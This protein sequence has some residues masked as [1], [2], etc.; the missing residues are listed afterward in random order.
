MPMSENIKLIKQCQKG[1]HKAFDKVINQYSGLIYGI[2]L[3]YCKN[4][5]EAEDLLQ[6]C[7]IIIIEKIKHFRFEGSF[8][9]WLKR[10]T[11]N[12]CINYLR[13]KNKRMFEDIDE[14]LNRGA[15]FVDENIFSKMSA[16]EIII[17]INQLPEGYRTVFNLHV[18]DGYK[19]VEIAEMLNIT[20]STSRSQYKK[21]RELLIEKVL[22]LQNING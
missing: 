22:K 8:E 12:T 18:I 17:L 19:H 20:D 5:S 14:S 11:V 21:A 10:L 4:K 16:N 15:T 9:G 2:C 6:E 1:S 7:L 13:D 3:R